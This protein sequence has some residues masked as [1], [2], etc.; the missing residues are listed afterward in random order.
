MNEKGGHASST[1]PGRLSSPTI[2][3]H[4]I[5]TP[6][7]RALPPR[8]SLLVGD[9]DACAAELDRLRASAAALLRRSGP[10]TPADWAPLAHRFR[11]LRESLVSQRAGASD[12]AVAV[13]GAAADAALRARDW[14]EFL[15]S[16]SHLV[17]V[18]EAEG[19][20]GVASTRPPPPPPPPRP[21]AWGS[22]DD[23]ETPPPA[24]ATPADEEPSRW[25]PGEALAALVLYFAAAAPVP[26]CLD[27]A[28]LLRKAAGMAKQG[29]R[30]QGDHLP[31]DDLE[32]ALAVHAAVRAGDAL[33]VCALLTGP[34][35]AGRRWR[36]AAVCGPA[37]ARARRAGV[38]TLAASHRSLPAAVAVSRLGLGGGAGDGD[39]GYA[40]LAALV[41]AE[42]EG[43]EGGGGG[44]GQ[45]WAARAL[46]GAVEGGELVFRA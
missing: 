7:R 13:Y 38:A 31:P 5:T 4:S 29:R 17:E 2:V 32:F 18:E 43:S 23:E 19:G 46:P 45:A 15:K 14:G 30:R 33:R 39:G 26:Q 20:G 25:R 16:A 3:L 40:A 24:P 21:S 36:A 1:S 44:S 9:L 28:R 12:L 34:D 8:P 35:T 27:A 42:A 37:L 11:W 6:S 10:T 22:S 41:R